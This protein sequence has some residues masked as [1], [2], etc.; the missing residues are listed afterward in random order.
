[1]PVLFSAPFLTLKAS[2]IISQALLFCFVVIRQLIYTADGSPSLYVPQLNVSYHSR[3]GAYTESEQVYLQ[4]GLR[5][6]LHQHALLNLLEIGFG[7]GLNALLTLQ[8]TAFQQQPV[9]YWTIEPHPLTIAEAEQLHYT[10]AD[11]AIFLQLHTA[12]WE[13]DV[14]LSP[15]FIL[16]KTRTPAEQILLASNY[17][18]LIYFDAFAPAVQPELWTV[19]IFEKLYDA[20]QSGGI[21]TT[22]SSKGSVQR[23]MQM[24]G[25]TVRKKP[26]PPGKR[27]MIQAT[28]P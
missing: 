2:P 3:Y 26:G 5:P 7:T 21:L 28:K 9:H 13:Q 27:E 19:S 22:Y 20:L 8:E 15:T 16:H 25:F 18:H 4:H 23:A 24:A 1:M 17:F 14:M 12:L 10:T 6:L 11:K